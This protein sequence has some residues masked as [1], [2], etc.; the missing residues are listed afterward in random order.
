MLRSMT[1][2][3]EILPISTKK[4]VFHFELRRN[5]PTNQPRTGPAQEGKLVRSSYRS[6]R[7]NL[8][9]FPAH[10]LWSW[11]GSFFSVMLGHCSASSAFNSINLIWSSGTSSSENIASTGHSGSQRAQSIHSSGWITRKFGPS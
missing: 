10:S 2:L 5:G 11:G 9:G 6:R 4:E 3:G 1:F 7:S 8:L